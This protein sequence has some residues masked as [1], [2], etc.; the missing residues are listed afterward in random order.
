MDC[1]TVSLAI[2]TTTKTRLIN[3]AVI[4]GVCFA[5][6]QTGMT[7]SGWGDLCRVHLRQRP[8]DCVSAP[9]NNRRE[10]DR[11]RDPV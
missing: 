6:F 10:D 9:R 3:A 8:L 1:F 2:G 5:V 7:L 4:I 11:G